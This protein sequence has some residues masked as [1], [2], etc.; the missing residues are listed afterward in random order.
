MN[1]E[2][3]RKNAPIGATG[4]IENEGKIYYIKSECIWYKGE[5]WFSTFCHDEIKP[6]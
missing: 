6:L 1:I 5:W 2:E 3:I 4:Y